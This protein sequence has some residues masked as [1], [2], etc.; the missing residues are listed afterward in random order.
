MVAACASSV[1]GEEDAACAGTVLCALWIS[2]DVLVLSARGSSSLMRRLIRTNL[3][4][5]R[6]LKPSSASVAIPMSYM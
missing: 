1:G 6:R 2:R 3:F 4:G 5:T